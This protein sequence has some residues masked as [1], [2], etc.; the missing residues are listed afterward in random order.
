MNYERKNKGLFFCETPCIMR[1]LLFVCSN[2]FVVFIGTTAV[3]LTMAFIC[4]QLIAVFFY[5]VIISLHEIL[6]LLC[7]FI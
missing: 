2:V 4:S 3:L 6:C 1:M 5:F 7:Q